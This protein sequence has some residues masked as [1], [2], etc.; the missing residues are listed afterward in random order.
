VHRLPGQGKLQQDVLA[1]A[2]CANRDNGSHAM[3]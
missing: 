3:P 2:A 1:L